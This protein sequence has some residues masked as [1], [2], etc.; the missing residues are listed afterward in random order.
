MSKFSKSLLVLL[1]VTLIA[2]VGCHKKQTAANCHM[3]K[4]CKMS[5]QKAQ[6][7]GSG[8]AACQKSC[9]KQQQEGAGKCCK[10]GC[11]CPKCAKK[12]ACKKQCAKPDANDA[13]A[14]K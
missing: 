10:E 7:E 12:A 6:A 14:P 3:D 4:T 9:S 1:A 2:F 11:T 8:Q 5:C 13:A